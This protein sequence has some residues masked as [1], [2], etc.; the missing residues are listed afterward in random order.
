METTKEVPKTRLDYNR[1]IL[2]LLAAYIERYPEMRFGQAL[3][4]LRIAHAFKTLK[5]S[6]EDDGFYDY[7]LEDNF[8]EEPSNTL[9]RVYSSIQTITT[10]NG[11]N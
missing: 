6:K 11:N 4:N 5:P 9:R 1:E 7:H 2:S 10:E 8:Y 3:H